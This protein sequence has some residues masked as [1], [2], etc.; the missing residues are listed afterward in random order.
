[1]SKAVFFY[2]CQ[3]RSGELWVFEQSGTLHPLQ[4]KKKN[5]QCEHILYT[6]N[7]ILPL[8]D[9]RMTPFCGRLAQIVQKPIF[10]FVFGFRLFGACGWL[11]V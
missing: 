6:G 9:Y 8:D 4:K 11:L 10:I 3:Y 5:E 1:M 2:T 7:G